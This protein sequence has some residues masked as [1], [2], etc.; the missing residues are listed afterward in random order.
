MPQ[1]VSGIQSS[2]APPSP[3]IFLI[4]MP[5]AGKTYWGSRLSESFDIRFAD[6]DVLVSEHEQAGIPALFAAYGEKG[7]R[8]REQKRLHQLIKMTTA[9]TIVAAGGGTP[10]YA[11]NMEKMKQAGT[12]IYLQAEAATLISNLAQSPEERPLHRGRTDLPAYLSGLLAARIR[13]YGQA[14]HIFA[15]ENIS[16]ATF[17]EIIRSCIGRH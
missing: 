2:V 14:H 9:P 11:D 6:L 8:E 13:Y 15:V 16:I 4:G 1:P 12:V 7:F 10:C 3:L 17:A 5:G